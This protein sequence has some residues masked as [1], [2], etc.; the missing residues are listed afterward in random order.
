MTS[1]LYRCWLSQSLV[2]ISADRHRRRRLR[3]ALG[4][5][6]SSACKCQDGHGSQER[7]LMMCMSIVAHWH[8]ID[9][10]VFA[11]F[12]VSLC[13]CYWTAVPP[14][15]PG[16]GAASPR[17]PPTHSPLVYWFAPSCCVGATTAIAVTLTIVLVTSFVVC[18]SFFICKQLWNESTR[19]CVDVCLYHSLLPSFLLQLLLGA[20]FVLL[21][22]SCKTRLF[23]LVP[24]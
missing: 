21:S 6:T 9:S 13:V 7:Y 19:C 16:G 23:L 10:S 1:L 4:L 14:L 20:R 22:T 5:L 18:F 2:T 24:H 12:F 15:L 8:V 17:H 3:R 11:A